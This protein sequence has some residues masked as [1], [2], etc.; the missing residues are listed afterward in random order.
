MYI[1]DVPGFGVAAPFGGAVHMF[2]TKIAPSIFSGTTYRGE[3]LERFLGVFADSRKI[4]FHFDK[5]GI[6]K[7]F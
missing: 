1:G 6:Q 5:R 2:E 7:D 4:Y 3:L